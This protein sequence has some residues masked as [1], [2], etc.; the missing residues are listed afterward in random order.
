VLKFFLSFLK[1]IEK[2]KTLNVFLW[3]WT[4]GLKAFV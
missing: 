1:K 2:K 3:C 4:L